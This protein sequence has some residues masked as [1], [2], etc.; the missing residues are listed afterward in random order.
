MENKT[1]YLLKNLLLFIISAGIPQIISFFMI[2]VYTACLSE[3]EYGISDILTNTVQLL[4]PFFSLQMQDA[5]L[6]YSMDKRF[7]PK[8]VFSI[9]VQVTL[10][11]GI[12]LAFILI[13]IWNVPLFEITWIYLLFIFAN[14]LLG[15]LN[16]ICSYFC[17]GID[18]VKV[19]TSASVILNLLTVFLNIVL[20][21]V[22]HFGLYGFL[23]ANTIG[24][25]GS[26]LY[27]F[28][29]ADLFYYLKFVQIST[30][31]R[32]DM[33]KM[34]IP[35]IFSALAWWINNASDKYILMYFTNVSIVGI[36]AVSYKIPTLLSA[37]SNVIAKAFS[38]SAIKEFDKDDTD[39]FLGNVY[40][41]VS[42]FMVLCCA[43]IIFLNI[44]MAC[45]LF[46][47]GF[48][49]AWIC[50]PPLVLAVLFNQLSLLCEN[51][52][53]ALKKTSITCR[54][55][56]IG[57]VLNTILNFL[58]IPVFG[59]YGA[60]VATIIGFVS[61]WLLRYRS[62]KKIVNLKNDIKK[63]TVS[64][65]LLTIQTFFSYFGN[66]LLILQ[67]V[68]IFMILFIYRAS[69]LELAYALIKK[70]KSGEQ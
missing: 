2:P 22:F 32:S 58:L 15:S 53:L 51:I 59:A 13:F 19:V 44:P 60:A 11:G 21:K 18:Q 46:S 65:L 68:T 17:R 40:S 24:I 57:A 54:T 49:N 8:D 69:I 62:L 39:G 7:L 42:L 38:I 3:A 16:N 1:K 37:L 25:L 26:V 20:L 31:L 36:Y 27:Q 67:A 66:R 55:S 43:G 70:K 10:Y 63:E 23:L 34:S 64:Y 56:I 4:T 50:V 35:M 30:K 41:T 14:Y 29:K 12:L 47:K 6:R 45:F 33:I 48:F 61:V 5:V 9:G 52:F 28:I